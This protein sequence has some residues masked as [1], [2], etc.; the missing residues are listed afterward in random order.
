METENYD[1]SELWKLYFFTKSLKSMPNAREE[2][3]L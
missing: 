1:L 2:I 3:I